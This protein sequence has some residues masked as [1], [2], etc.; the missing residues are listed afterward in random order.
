MNQTTNLLM[1]IIALLSL[2]VLDNGAGIILQ[3]SVASKEVKATLHLTKVSASLSYPQSNL[4]YPQSNYISGLG[5]IGGGG[6]KSLLSSYEGYRNCR[7]NDTK[8]IPTIGIGWNLEANRGIT[9]RLIGVGM[10]NCIND[11]EV[12]TLYE[13]SVNRAADELYDYLPWARNLP[14]GVR[15]VL[16]RMSFN[17]GIGNDSR[18]L[19]SFKNTLAMLKRGDYRGAAEGFRNSK[20]CSDVKSRRCN[21]EADRIARG[22]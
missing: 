15:E 10:P 19:L 21:Q 7:Y 14:V 2:L 5:Y 22:V 8:G 3:T 6:M 9:G 1:I 18:G 16:I 12:N 20:W 13:Y 4:S 17:M 11:R